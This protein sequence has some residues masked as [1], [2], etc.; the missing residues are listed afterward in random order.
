M[1]TKVIICLNTNCYVGANSPI[2]V[3]HK[4][5]AHVDSLFG[6][7]Y[8]VINGVVI[9]QLLLIM[10]H[11][12]NWRETKETREAIDGKMSIAVKSHSITYSI[13][14]KIF[15]Q[16]LIVVADYKLESISVRKSKRLDISMG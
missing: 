8:D 14:N 11:S 6:Y 12:L 13:L 3:L 1:I 7:H 16:H 5:I 2:E 15:S 9:E 4:R 10:L